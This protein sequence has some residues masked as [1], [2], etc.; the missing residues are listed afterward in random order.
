MEAA[1]RDNQVRQNETISYFVEEIF[2]FNIY[3]KVA[4]T[5]I[6]TLNS[7]LFTEMGYFL[8]SGA[9]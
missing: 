2:G 6:I 7:D 8:L 3:R 5:G 4:S 1:L 9:Y